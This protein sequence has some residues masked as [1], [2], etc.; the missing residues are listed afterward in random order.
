MR[1]F[2]VVAASNAVAG[3]SGRLDKVGRLA[4]LLKATPPD[5]IEIVVAFLTGEPR[6]GRLGIGWAQLSAARDVPPADVPS[7]EIH[8]VDAS[9]A[10]IF[11]TSG[12][13]SAAARTRLLR[14]LL[15]RATRDEQ[16][17]LL[18]LLSGE[19]RQGALE[20]VLLEAVARAA[21]IAAARVRRATMLAGDIGVV[22]QNGDRRGRGCAVA[23]HPAA[24]QAGPADARRLGVGCRRGSRRISAR[25]SFEYKL[26]GARIQ[27]HK[28]GDEVRVF[29]RNLR[30]VTIAVPEVVDRRSRHA[31]TRAGPRRRSHRPS[32]GRHAAAVSDHDAP[33]RPQA[34]GRS[35]EGDLADHPVLLRLRCTWTATHSSTSR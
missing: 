22:A 23:L 33:V 24:V 28:V 13:G 32:P 9:F 14:E 31:R 25:R 15:G 7:L 35:P 8:D 1:L 5:E 16:D 30:D 20:G 29:S 12:T 21:G 19:L 17:F 27:A 34:G 3:T 2:E 18:R 10:R 11:S 6:Q 4:D 26:D